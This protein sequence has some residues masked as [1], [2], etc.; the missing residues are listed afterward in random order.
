MTRLELYE[1][2]WKEPMTHVAKRF[3]VSDVA[4]RKTCIKHNI[5]TPPL[6]YWAKLAHRKRVSQPS[7]P[8]LKQGERDHIHLAIRPPRQLPAS[9]SAVLEAAQNQQAAPEMA[10]VVPKDRPKDLHAITSLVERAIRKTTANDEGFLNWG[11]K[12]QASIVVGRDSIERIIVLLDSF[13]QA[14]AAR[15][16]ETTATPILRFVSR[17]NRSN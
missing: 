3:G 1:L 16:Y 8:P 17:T 15:G 2:I 10:I 4:L 9:V 6:G 7:L 5:P 14:L 12:D 13:I 11:T